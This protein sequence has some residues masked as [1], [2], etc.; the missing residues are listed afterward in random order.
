MET[1]VVFVV[2][3]I[4]LCADFILERGLE[5]LNMKH[6]S[7]SLPLN[8]QGIYDEKEYS[9]FQ[10][11]QREKNGFGLISSG[12]SFLVLLLFFV[13]GGFGYY[14]AWIVGWTD[15][16]VLQTVVFMLGLLFISSVLGIPFDYYATFR[17]EEKFGFNKMTVKTYWF[18]TF[19][20]LLLGCVLGGVLL[21]AVTW[22]YLWAGTLFWLYAWGVA[23]LFSVFMAMFYSRLIVPLFNRQTLLEE[24]SLK[25]KIKHFAESVR[26][27]IDNIYVIDGS[28]RST[29]ANAYFTGLGT[30][31]RIVLYDTLIKELAEEEIVAVLAHE[32]GHYKKRHTLQFM[33][34]S[35]LQV[36]FLFWLFSLFVN[37]PALSEA[38][39]GDKTYFQ[40]GM[41][42][43]AI[44]FEPVN[45]VLGIWMN[46]WSRKN[47][48]EADAFAARHYEG[49]FLIS[50]LKKISVKALGNLTPHPLYESVYYS[51]PSLLKRIAAIGE[52]KVNANK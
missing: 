21:A 44:L 38:L 3:F 10:D 48:Y 9:R 13:F 16:V 8:L 28:K 43:F 1:Q 23:S 34:A 15:Q 52:L 45:L 35:V 22:F 42:A 2:I 20:E 14:N 30:Q 49:Q 50:G 46:A 11:Y 36:G 39:G 47:E 51:H 29:K 12:F 5:Y 37:I 19:K 18:D 33:I 4:V 27:G 25:E 24:G 6:M 31:K 17:I 32:I 7:P 40:L 26:F 41:V